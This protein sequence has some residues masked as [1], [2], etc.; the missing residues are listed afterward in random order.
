MEFDPSPDATNR[1]G[2]EIGLGRPQSVKA[3]GEQGA[4]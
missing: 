4:A 3:L 1:T 2:D